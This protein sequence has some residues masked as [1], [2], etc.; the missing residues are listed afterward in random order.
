MAKS[1][2]SVDELIAHIEKSIDNAM[3]YDTVPL[4]VK[5]LNQSIARKI[6]RIRPSEYKRRLALMNSA[7]GVYDAPEHTA[8]AS[9]NARSNA[10][11]VT[12]VSEVS[13]TGNFLNMLGG[14]FGGY[15][16]GLWANGFPRP[17]LT[18]AQNMINAYGRVISE[19]LAEEIYR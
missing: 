3:D 7:F 5:V 2:N 11:W 4:M 10:S 9:S 16:P 17:A 13:G 14:D 12:G 6:Y 1:F 8:W 18:F 15:N 19:Y